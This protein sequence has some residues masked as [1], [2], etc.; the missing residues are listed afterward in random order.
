MGGVLSIPSAN[1]TARPQYDNQTHHNNNSTDISA[2]NKELRDPFE[3]LPFRWLAERLGES[4]LPAIQ[5]AREEQLRAQ[6]EG[7]VEGSNVTQH[8]ETPYIPHILPFTRW[9]AHN[10]S[11]RSTFVVD[12]PKLRKKARLSWYHPDDTMVPRDWFQGGLLA[13]IKYYMPFGIGGDKK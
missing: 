9:A 10:E 12:D 2:Q 11:F 6:R 13:D 3:G 8:H 1:A 5:A 4:V 7:R